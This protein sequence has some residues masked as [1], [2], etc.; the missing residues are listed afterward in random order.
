M[1]TLRNVSVTTERIGPMSERPYD[2]VFDKV[3]KLSC[4]IKP[5]CWELVPVMSWPTNKSQVGMLSGP[6]AL[7]YGPV[8]ITASADD[9]APSVRLFQFDYQTD[10][11]FDEAP[12]KT[13]RL[14]G[15]ETQ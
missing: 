1:K 2:N 8:K 13:E 5:G 15:P 3:K 7:A 9:T 12:V 10:Q 11:M 14:E 6:S 4:D